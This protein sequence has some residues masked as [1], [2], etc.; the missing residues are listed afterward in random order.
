MIRAENPNA[1]LFIIEL[2]PGLD[3]RNRLPQEFL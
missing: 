1:R 2:A 3:F